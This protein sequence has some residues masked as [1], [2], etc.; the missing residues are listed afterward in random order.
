MTQVHSN[1]VQA[2]E[3]L[4]SPH[5]IKVPDNLPDILK[6]FTKH[7]IRTQPKNIVEEAAK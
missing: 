6:S 4:Y 3:P 1:M 7:I 5:Q 2:N